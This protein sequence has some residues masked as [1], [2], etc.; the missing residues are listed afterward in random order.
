MATTPMPDTYFLGRRVLVTGG[1]GFIGGEVAAMVLGMQPAAV[2]VVDRFSEAATV[3]GRREMLADPR[4]RVECFDLAD[5]RATEDCVRRHRPDLVLHLAAETH[6][7]RSFANSVAFTRSNVMGTHNLLEAF[8]KVVL[9]EPVPQMAR[10]PKPDSPCSEPPSSEPPSPEPRLPAPRFLFMSTDEVYG[11]GE[12]VL[13][14]GGHDPAT[15]IL[16]PTNPYSASKAA[17]EMLCG[18]YARSFG[19]DVVVLRCNNVYGPRQHCEKV[20]PRFIL[21]AI[22]GVPLT[23]HGDGSQQR[24]FLFVTD[25]ARAVLVAAARA[26]PGE[27]INVGADREITVLQ[28]ASRVMQTVAEAARGDAAGELAGRTAISDASTCRFERNRLFNDYRYPVRTERITQL[29]W[30]P[31]VALADG[32]RDTAVDLFRSWTHELMPADLSA[33]VYG[34]GHFDGTTALKRQPQLRNAIVPREEGKPRRVLLFGAAGWIGGK[35]MRMGRLE[36][37]AGDVEWVEAKARLEDTPALVDQLTRYRPDR[38]VLAA[39]ITG[40]PN[41]DWCEASPENEA[42]TVLVNVQAT[43]MLGRLCAHMGIPLATFATGCIYTSSPG[44][45]AKREQDPPNF[46][47]SLYSRTKAHAEQILATLPGALILRL[48]MPVGED[49]DHPRNLVAKLRGYRVITDIPNS[50]SVLPDL[51]PAALRMIMAGDTGV[52]NFTN[53]GAVSPAT[54]RRMDDERRLGKMHPPAWTTIDSGERLVAEGHVKAARS[55]CVLDASKL[56]ARAAH[57]GIRVRTAEEALTSL[58]G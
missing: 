52:Y 12:R 30:R 29:G 47:G 25:A 43:V 2:V 36:D 19:M 35:L 31:E 7:D 8:R 33:A 6:V 44:E 24:S 26:E 20:V 39:G 53:P 5:G 10:E 49:L 54:I 22:A 55:N 46:F 15:A 56:V 34:S 17:A 40:R 50:V 37:G 23:I 28:L 11:S 16:M 13:T 42:H 51:L 38:V 27:I 14:E 18:A 21:Q 41:V 57:H 1:L 9:H 4:L 45:P 48:R 58:L 3:W 32:L